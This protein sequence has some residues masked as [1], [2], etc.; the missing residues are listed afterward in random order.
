M[1]LQTRALCAALREH[2][3]H[4]LIT[5]PSPDFSSS[6]IRKQLQLFSC[7]RPKTIFIEHL[8]RYK[9]HGLLRTIGA[10]VGN[11]S[12]GLMEAPTVSLPVVNIGSRQ[13]CR[14]R[15]SNVIDAAPSVKSIR[16]AINKALSSEFRASLKGIQNPYGSGDTSKRITRVLLKAT[17]KQ[18]LLAKKFC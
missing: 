8:G 16:R 10:M 9:Y 2:S 11:S 17:S 4:I 15:S 14:E 18:A 13:K 12:S 3:G 6:A 7:T 1:P 5:A